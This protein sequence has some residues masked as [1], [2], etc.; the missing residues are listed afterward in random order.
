MSSLATTSGQIKDGLYFLPNW[1]EKR[2]NN[3]D[4]SIQNIVY[5]IQVVLALCDFWDQEKVAFAKNCISQIFS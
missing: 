3:A 2:Y 4:F 1:V 5:C